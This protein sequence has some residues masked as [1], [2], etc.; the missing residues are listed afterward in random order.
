MNYTKIDKL[1]DDAVAYINQSRKIYVLGARGSYALA[2]YFYYMVKEFKEDVEL[3]ISGASDFTD[4][5]LHT[6]EKDLLF[7]ISFYPYT[8]F[9][10]EVTKYFKENG[11]KIISI[12]D[13]KILY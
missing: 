7:T 4:K 8:N 5:L 12:T 1:L 11:N 10:C 9:T 6:N 3:M 2:H 13:K